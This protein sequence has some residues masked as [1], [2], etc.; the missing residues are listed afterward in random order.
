MREMTKTLTQRYIRNKALS[1]YLG[2]TPMTIF[3]WRRDP[4][5]DFPQAAVVNG[6]EYTCLDEI[7]TWLKARVV[8]RNAPKAK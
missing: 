7:D 4:K 1:E 2:V 8:N 6:V 3:R 5:L